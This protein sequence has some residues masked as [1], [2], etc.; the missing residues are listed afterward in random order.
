MKYKILYIVPSLEIG[1][2]ERVTVTLANNLDRDI[3]EPYICCIS[4]AG[5]LADMLQE[6]DRLFVV[7]NRGRINV[8]SI[9]YILDLAEKLSIDL[10]HSHELPGLIYGIPVAKIKRLPIVFTKHGYFGSFQENWMV[11]LIEKYFSRW[12][13]EYICVSHELRERMQKQLGVNEK[14][15]SVI[16]NGV[17][18]VPKKHYPSPDRGD[19][20]LIGSIGRLAE[21]KN[22][23]L[24]IEA[25]KE[26][27][28]EY[29]GCRLQIIGDGEY[30][31]KLED[32]IYRRS[33][34]DLVSLPGHKLDPLSYLSKFDI[35]IL[36]SLHEGHSISLL[37]ALSQSKICLVSNV[38][39][40]TEIIKDGE[41]GF[42]F[43]SN[44]KE[45]LVFQMK[46]ILDRIHSERMDRIRQRAYNSFVSKYSMETMIDKYQGLYKKYLN[47]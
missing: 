10:I 31:Q 32:L 28:G 35:F 15:V 18:I 45:D 42:I 40:N 43:E 38:G 19:E 21:V 6:K 13:S 17:E 1:G 9:R 27:Q 36:T 37:E 2:L 22:Y 46:N 23:S 12:V 16:Y 33:L 3:F 47:K 24:L 7:G 8:P 30:K 11:K 39:G 26:I 14:K 5:D 4:R 44:N 41:N 29:P 25:F 34:S 20:V